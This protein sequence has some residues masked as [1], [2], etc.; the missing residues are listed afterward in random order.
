M[1]IERIINQSFLAR[2]PDILLANRELTIEQAIQLAYDEDEALWLRM[3]LANQH[4]RRG[5]DRG[6]EEVI[7]IM[8]DTVYERLRGT[9]EQR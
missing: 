9:N 4:D 8:S 6:A 3:S 1:D 2:V 7:R 5:L